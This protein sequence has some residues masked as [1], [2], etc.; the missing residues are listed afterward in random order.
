[1]SVR[2]L[3]RNALNRRRIRRRIRSQV[4]N[5]LRFAGTHGWHPSTRSPV[6]AEGRKFTKY[7]ALSV[8]CNCRQLPTLQMRPYLTTLAVRPSCEPA[9]LPGNI[10]PMLIDLATSTE[11]LKPP[12]TASNWRSAPCGRGSCCGL[13]LP[14]L[15]DRD[16]RQLLSE[17]G[18]S[19]MAQN[20]QTPP[21]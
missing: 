13:D 3:A 6:C 5:L 19:T 2:R 12:R 11:A 9:G 18:L 4:R 7:S 8:N 20:Q 17:D 16:A 14:V 10:C 21:Y 15:S 1:M